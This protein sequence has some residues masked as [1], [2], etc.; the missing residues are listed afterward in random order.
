VQKEIFGLFLAKECALY[1]TSAKGE[2]CIF[3]TKRNQFIIIGSGLVLILV[4]I[5]IGFV[6]CSAGC[7]I[8][9]FDPDRDTAGIMRNF[10]EDWYWLIAE[11]LQFDVPY[12]LQT[13]SPDKNSEYYGKLY[14]KVI[15]DSGQTAAFATYYKLTPETGRIQ[16]ISVNRRF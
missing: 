9:D 3:M 14:I 4:F 2:N 6:K 11:G 13:R 16:F 7:G 12:M 15:R 8:Y 5:I 1:Y 10:K